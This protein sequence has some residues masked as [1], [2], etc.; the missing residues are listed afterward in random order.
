MMS[1]LRLQNE[2]ILQS[3]SSDKCVRGFIQHIDAAPFG[4][5]CYNEVSVRLYHEVAK[6]SPLFCDATGTIVALPKR[7]GK[8]PTVYYYAIVVKHPVHGRAPIAVAELITE[9]NTV[10]SVSFF[11]QSFRRAE[12]LL[13]GASNL[14]NPAQVIIDRSQV[15]L[16]SFLQVYC[17]ESIEDY[18]HRAFRI[19]DF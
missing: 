7:I 15:L 8:K 1:L 3:A 19:K 16:I 10:L 2:L 12:S 11:L 18:L 5:I 14:I 13:Y 9:D 4:V 6:S 17:M